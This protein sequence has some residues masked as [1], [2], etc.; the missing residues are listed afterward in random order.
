[1]SAHPSLA[2]LALAA[3]TLG[4]SARAQ[5]PAASPSPPLRLPVFPGGVE[6]VVVDVV[7]ADDKGQAVA[8]LT[9][10]DFTLKEDDA[11]REILS[12]EAVAPE[13]LAAAMR[14]GQ[15]RLIRVFAIV[16]DDLHLGA[17]AGDRAK[18]ALRG[19]I[20]SVL[21]DSDDVVLLRTSTGQ[22]SSGR[23]GTDRVSLSV[24]LENMRGLGTQPRS[25]EMSDEEAMQIATLRD[26]E[27]QNSVYERYLKCGLLLREPVGLLNP[28]PAQ[29]EGTGVGTPRPTTARP[30]SELVETWATEQHQR[31]LVGIRSTYAGLE[32]LLRALTPLRGRKSV[33]LA[34]EGFV[35]DRGLVEVKGVVSAAS[36]ANA[37]VTFLDVR[38]LT[39]RALTAAA[40]A[41]PAPDAS[42]LGRLHRGRFLGAEATERL[43]EDTGG[44]TIRG[45]DLGQGL[46]RLADESRS[47]YLLGY[48]PR[49]P[50]LD[51]KFRAI[52]VDVKRPGLSVRARRGYYAVPRAGPPPATVAVTTP[53][54]PIAP[55][56]PP[57]PP[58]AQPEA[59]SAYAGDAATARARV[60]G[61][62]KEEAN[63]A[64]A[65]LKAGNAADEVIEAAALTHAAA[66]LSAA[67]PAEHQAR[68]ARNAAALVRDPARRSA[69]ERRVLLGLAHGF[70]DARQWQVAQELA[71]EATWR[72]PDD[73]EAQLAL[74][75]V[76]ETT[77]SVVDGGR[78]PL[79]DQAKLTA[80]YD[81]LVSRNPVTGF[82]AG[83]PGGPGRTPDTQQRMSQGTGP[84]SE[85]R[86]RQAAES[87]RRALKARPDLLEARL[88]L[89]RTLALLSELKPAV[90]ELE[91]VAGEA[92]P[93][94][95]YLARLFL[96]DLKEQQDDFP[97]AAG[98]Y[99]AALA[100]RPGSAV[101][102]LAMARAEEA[103]GERAAAQAVLESLLVEPAD[104]AQ[105]DPWWSYRLRPLGRWAGTLEG[106]P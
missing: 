19:L 102:L 63:R 45:H 35:L 15:A 76:Q 11:A 50:A 10:A 8:G 26:F 55:P 3:A 106:A 68:A 29:G 28:S 7:V 71:Q 82:N 13:D 4:G 34:S 87:Y 69:L 41:P 85:T 74:G 62:S 104:D 22:T 70:L 52:R 84:T 80:G 5:Q 77:G 58:P 43:A 105:G 14:A 21:R 53:P 1:M 9:A 59:V 49:D 88:R 101:A 46:R 94:L 100:A 92:D 99:R 54:I 25:C 60:A 42:Q 81:E 66:A 103:G 96:G 64:V 67:D 27:V 83:V 20:S 32:R 72:L 31:S 23:V 33:I 65:A 48:S 40:D 78:R 36:D 56:A 79:P 37:A 2:A 17:A 30:G 38:A 18:E 51:G 57:A 6:Q 24:A 89:G 61:W 86:L 73:A 44:T 95:A 39:P 12:F 75:I 47:Y 97:G 90:K 16:F 91:S 98:E 93:G